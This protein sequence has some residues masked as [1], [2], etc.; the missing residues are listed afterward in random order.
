MVKYNRVGSVQTKMFT[1]SLIGN[2]FLSCIYCHMIL[3]L[4][5]LSQN[6]RLHQ[7][8][9]HVN[10]QTRSQLSVL[11]R[12]TLSHRDSTT[13]LIRRTT[14]VPERHDRHWQIQLF[15][16]SQEDIRYCLLKIQVVTCWDFNMS[17]QIN[18]YGY[19]DGREIYS[20]SQS[21]NSQSFSSYRLLFET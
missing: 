1:R 6:K 9:L 11:L 20:T 12:V 3:N 4:S 18:M 7:N 5:L 14:E 15:R 10:H 8:K 21:F 17:N 2:L 19:F 13:R 16:N